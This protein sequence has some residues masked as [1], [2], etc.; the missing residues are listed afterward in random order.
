MNQLLYALRRKRSKNHLDKPTRYMAGF[1]KYRKFVL[2]SL[3]KNMLVGV[4]YQFDYKLT[5]KQLFGCFSISQTHSTKRLNHLF[6]HWKQYTEMQ[7]VR[8]I[9]YKLFSK[10]MM[11]CNKK[12][13]QRMLKKYFRKWRNQI[14]N[15]R[16]ALLRLK[17]SEPLKE[18]II[19]RTVEVI[20]EIP[21]ERTVEVTNKKSA[22]RSAVNH[23]EKLQ[24]VFFMRRYL[25]LWRDL[26]HRTDIRVL[27]LE[28]HSKTKTVLI[29]EEVV[30]EI[31]RK[32]TQIKSACAQIERL[33]RT[34]FLGKCCRRWR[35]NAYRININLLTI[36]IN[37]PPV[38]VKV[39]KE[40]VNQVYV[41][42]V[43][44]VANKKSALK[45]ATIHA[46]NLQ[47]MFF[48]AKYCRVWR[49]LVYRLNILKLEEELKTPAK[50]I[51]VEKIV[52]IPV[53]EISKK[54]FI[55]LALMNSQKSQRGFFTG[56]Y[57]RKWRNIAHNIQI[58]ELK[59]ELKK[60]PKVIHYEEEVVKEIVN[61]KS[62]MKTAVVHCSRL[63]DH[64]FLAKWCRRWRDLCRAI[65]IDYL[66]TELAQ[67]INEVTVEVPVHKQEIVEIV[68]EVT[69]K[70]SIMRNTCCHVDKLQTFFYLSKYCRRWRELVY[71]LN[72]AALADEISKKPNEIITEVEVVKEV[73]NKKSIIQQ[74]CKKSTRLQD[75][76]H[77]TKYCRKWRNL[78]SLIN[79]HTLAEE[80]DNKPKEIITEIIKEIPIITVE[81][82]QVE[83]IANK[84]AIFKNTADHCDKTQRA[85]FL[86]KYMNKWRT[87]TQTILLSILRERYEKKE[88]TVVKEIVHEFE[89]IKSVPQIKE[90]IIEVPVVTT[91]EVTTE[92]INKKS[93]MKK[94][95][96]HIDRNQNYFFLAK[97]CRR[98]RGLV[99]TMKCHQQTEELR[100]NLNP[101]LED[102]K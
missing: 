95:Y 90:V 12:Y 1:D 20:K 10:S 89:V 22:I 23:S 73:I 78:V 62:V 6:Q 43:N 33:Q 59:G 64:F 74:A 58:S 29:K 60:K 81:T 87:Y 35:G 48:L 75:S 40:I 98:W 96:V 100:R 77:L 67:P 68:R 39:E 21:V 24:R 26:A 66:K 79:I 93:T 37:K 27:E 52:E 47:K 9:H 41:E 97:Y 7:R 13:G 83:I 34:Y 55:K 32:D 14:Y 8:E 92:I 46:D 102:I 76:Y 30:T 11:V 101:F 15:S 44:V 51:Y 88:K 28:L 91:V 57:F 49:D 2:R 84:F 3:C 82:K 80:V 38:E 5:R 86:N 94:A 61:K 63:Q 18:V 17:L 53:E 69:Q 72:T 56:Y 70:K 25:M 65:E 36:E 54:D 85:Y 19:E 45:H 50:E 4:M 31:Y 42:K 71:R 99:Y 16:L